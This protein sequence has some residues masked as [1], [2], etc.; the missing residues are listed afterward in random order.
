MKPFANW[1]SE[2]IERLSNINE[3]PFI[4]ID[5]DKEDLDRYADWEQEDRMDNDYDFYGD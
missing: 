4:V 5:Y 1:M 2:E 3:E